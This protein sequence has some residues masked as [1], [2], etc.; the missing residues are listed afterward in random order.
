MPDFDVN[1]DPLRLSAAGE[2]DSLDLPRLVARLTPRA[3][4]L[5]ERRCYGRRAA[6]ARRL[7]PALLAHGRR[8]ARNACGQ[9]IALFATLPRR[10][11][12]LWTKCH[13]R[14]PGPV[15]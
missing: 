10:R 3:R 12:R 9:R 1:D 15:T 11:R 13:G 4:Q 2:D 8:A 7:A 14:P 6:P 5:A